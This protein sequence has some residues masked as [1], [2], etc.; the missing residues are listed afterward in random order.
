MIGNVQNFQRRLLSWY[1]KHQ[2]TL[3]WRANRP[4]PYHVLVSEFMLQQTQVATV[5]DYFHRFM[6]RFPTLQHLA[7]AP[8][9]HVLRLWQGLGYY[10]RAR[11]LLSA[12]RVIVKERGG[13]MP[14]S[15][16]GLMAL[17]G[18]GRYTAGAVASIAFGRVAPIVDGNVRRVICRLD[19]IILSPGPELT[20]HLWQK[21]Q[22]ILPSKS[23]GQFNSALMELG[24][25]VCTPRNP[26][27]PACPVREHCIAFSIGKVDQIPVPKPPRARPVVRRRVLCI[28]NKG[29]W[30]MEQRPDKGRWAGMWQF[31]TKP[32]VS[33]E[34]PPAG[35]KT[36]PFLRLTHDLT[37]RRYEFEAHLAAHKP[38]P[39]P[40]QRWMTPAQID[41]HPLPLPHVKIWKALQQLDHGR[42]PLG[43]LQ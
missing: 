41:Q 38:I 5:I 43:R 17:P 8:E 4:D 31:V 27:C 18:I 40:R 13:K 30:L 25:L 35:T 12:A 9:A 15:V 2:R 11:N 28:R 26:Q 10:S 39:S 22:D 32:F 6:E 19:A 37:H 21:A 24:A 29:C 42:Q 3:P 14:R 20:A 34:P 16:E 1:R 33:N 7:D 36:T 23:P